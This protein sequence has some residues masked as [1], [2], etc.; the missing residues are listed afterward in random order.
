LHQKG[1]RAVAFDDEAM[2]APSVAV[3]RAKHSRKAFLGKARAGF[4]DER[5]AGLRCCAGECAKRSG[6]RAV[7]AGCGA[8]DRKRRAIGLHACWR[9]HA[10]A[11]QSDARP[12]ITLMP[13][14]LNQ[15]RSE[16]SRADSQPANPTAIIA[17][18]ATAAYTNVW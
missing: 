8:P 6:S 7:E 9:A 15:G 10:G 17:T 14:R 13:P 12:A 2:C 1:G 4:A 3:H 16:P 11:N 5:R 18:M